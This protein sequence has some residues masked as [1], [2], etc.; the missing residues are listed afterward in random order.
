MVIDL[1]RRFGLKVSPPVA[2][3]IAESCGNDQAIVSQ[4]LRSSRCTSTLRRKRRR[5]SITRRLTRSVP[6]VPRAIFCAWRTSR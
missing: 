6:K 5:N 1:G 3:R 4:E 2:A